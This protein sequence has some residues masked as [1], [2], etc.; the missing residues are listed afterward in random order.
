M[1]MKS[2]EAI[3]IMIVLLR[4]LRAERAFLEAWT[5]FGGACAWAI[6]LLTQGLF[7]GATDTFPLQYC[8]AKK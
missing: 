7:T 3:K 4:L 2:I 1:T 6:G 8:T 5:V